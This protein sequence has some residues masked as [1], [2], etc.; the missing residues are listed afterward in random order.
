MAYYDVD[1][2]GLTPSWVK[3]D[4]EIDR[5]AHTI[6]LKC[7]AIEGVLDADP[8][9]EIA[10]FNAIACNKINNEELF[11]G[12]TKLQCSPMNRIQVEINDEIFEKC[13][14]HP[15]VTTID[16][17][18]AG[19]DAGSVIEYEMKLE[20]EASG[21]GG[22]VL[23]TPDYG[24]YN[25]AEYY[26]FYDPET[27]QKQAWNGTNR[28]TEIGYLKFTEVKNVKRVEVYGS[29]DCVGNCWI[30][31][32]GEGRQYWHYGE[33]ADDS[34]PVQEKLIWILEEPT[35][36]IVLNSSKHYG[37]TNYGCYLAYVRLIFE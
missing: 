9:T 27:G 10:L 35:N 14:L 15:I 2:G 32:N 20:Y 18:Y 17:Y 23:Y 29:G 7:A 21:G 30:E 25:N 5:E 34:V 1:I 22:S 8:K 26:F 4:I 16:E 28:G 37:S 11:N 33:A 24:E 31:C 36:V 12:G 19:P 6:T 13:A 3:P